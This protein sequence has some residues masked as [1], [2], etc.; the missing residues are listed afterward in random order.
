[1]S[2]SVPE[3]FKEAAATVVKI[4]SDV[5]RNDE[6][7][8]STKSQACEIVLNMTEKMPAVLRKVNEVKTDFWPALMQLLARCE[9][10]METWEASLDDEMGTKSDAYSTAVSSIGRIST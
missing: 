5:A 4:V 9:V 6:F 7:E 3:F 2:Q 1:M 10:D 8:E